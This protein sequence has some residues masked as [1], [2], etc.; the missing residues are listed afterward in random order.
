[1]ATTS[2]Q[3]SQVDGKRR[4][5]IASADYSVTGQ[6]L[7]VSITAENTVTLSTSATDAAIVGVLQNTP[8]ALDA[9]DV[10]GRWGGGTGLVK[11]GGNI[12]AGNPLTTNSSSQAVAAVSTNQVFGY[13]LHA[14]VSGDI[15]EFAPSYG[16]L[17]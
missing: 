7:I 12:A 13:A 10:V 17:A 11:A 14:G 15:I 6:F 4:G 1:M 3:A 8:K 9:A 2:R 16:I 5:F